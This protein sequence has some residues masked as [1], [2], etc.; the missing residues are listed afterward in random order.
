MYYSIYNCL[1]GFFCLELCIILI[2]CLIQNK[3][4]INY[5]K[6]KEV[7]ICVLDS[8]Y[9]FSLQVSSEDEKPH[10][11]CLDQSANPN[12]IAVPTILF[13]V[14]VSL[15]SKDSKT[16]NVTIQAMH[17][18]HSIEA[19]FCNP[20]CR[21]KPISITYFQHARVCSLSYLACKAHVPYYIVSLRP[22]WLY[23]IFSHCFIKKRDFF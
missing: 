9:L 8:I 1:L 18:Q 6:L 20:C 5:G 15:L 12:N 23:H 7:E 4:L 22:V 13:S 17:I 10:P 14:P 2:P 11:P 16:T 21:G 3:R 19:H